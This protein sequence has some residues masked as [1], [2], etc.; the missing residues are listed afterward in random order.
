VSVPLRWEELDDELD[1]RAFTM[2]VALRRIEHE[3]DLFE[4]VLAGGQS[5]DRAM[6]ELTSMAEG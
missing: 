2:A 6:A 1:R 5:L 3:G 4:P